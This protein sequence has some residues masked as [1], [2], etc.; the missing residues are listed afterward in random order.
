MF[1]GVVELAGAIRWAVGTI[2]IRERFG[3]ASDESKAGTETEALDTDLKRHARAVQEVFEERFQAPRSPDVPLD[4]LNLSVGE[5]FPA[6]PDWRVIP[7]PI[8]KNLYLA[9]RESHLAR[10]ADEEDAVECVRGVP[11][12]AA[13][14]VGRGEQPASFVVTDRGSV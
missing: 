14:T 7:Q 4:F 10:K 12:L 2:L 13:C 1:G 3:A 8:E 6:R 5:F 9:Q 11:P